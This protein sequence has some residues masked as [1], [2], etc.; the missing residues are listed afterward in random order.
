MILQG[1]TAHYWL[2]TDVFGAHPAGVDEERFVSAMAT[3]TAV[4]LGYE[5]G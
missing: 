5:V 1:A 4:L 2:L 3:A